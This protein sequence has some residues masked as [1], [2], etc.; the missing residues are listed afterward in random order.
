MNRILNI[1]NDFLNSD[2]LLNYKMFYED[3]EI[4]KNDIILDN[5]VNITLSFECIK[6]TVFNNFDFLNKSLKILKFNNAN[7]DL[8]EDI[9]KIIKIE[10]FLKQDI[11]S[12]NYLCFSYILDLNENIEQIYINFRK[13]YENEKSKDLIILLDNH[14]DK[15]KEEICNY[16][17]IKESEYYK[18]KDKFFNLLKI[19]LF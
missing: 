2:L 15:I 19:I 1:K 5:K 12:L 7:I 3:K 8:I 18:D 14:K 16:F 13:F 10:E 4:F 9:Y 17:Q 6:I 11:K